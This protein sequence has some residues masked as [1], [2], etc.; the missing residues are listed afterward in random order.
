MNLL[1][2]FEKAIIPNEK[3]FGYCL[4]PIHERGQ[5]K[6]KVFRQVFGIT[7]ADGQVLKKAI[8]EQID[9]MEFKLN[10]R[11]NLAKYFHYR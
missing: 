10:Q 6:A 3:I 2:N 8:L 5:H 11:I 4:N 1:P 7:Q 9:N